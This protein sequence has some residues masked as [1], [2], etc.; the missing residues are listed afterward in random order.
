M[1]VLK[2]YDPVCKYVVLFFMMIHIKESSN[3]EEIVNAFYLSS[4]FS[5]RSLKKK[6]GF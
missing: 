6:I 2:E 4:L 1:F 3:D 5:L